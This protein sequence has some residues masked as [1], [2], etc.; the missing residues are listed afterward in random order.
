MGL[1]GSLELRLFHYKHWLPNGELQGLVSALL[2]FDLALVLSI[3]AEPTV[4]A[5]KMEMCHVC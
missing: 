4:F 1:I 3:F 2:D 5:F